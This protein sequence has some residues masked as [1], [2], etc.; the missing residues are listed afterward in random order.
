MSTRK[1]QKRLKNIPVDYDEVKQRKNISVTPTAWNLLQQK[2][3]NSG[4][5]VSE[6]VERFARNTQG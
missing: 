6:L 3:K 5:S 1:G 4:I 2:A